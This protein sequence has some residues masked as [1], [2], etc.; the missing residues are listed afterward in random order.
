MLEHFV[1]SPYLRKDETLAIASDI[2]NTST[3]AI[4]TTMSQTQTAARA[5]SLEEDRNSDQIK[6]E[7]SR[8]PPS[9]DI[10]VTVRTYLGLH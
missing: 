4:A 3:N 7:K 5:D 8:R 1:C 2:N 10:L 9:K 6:K